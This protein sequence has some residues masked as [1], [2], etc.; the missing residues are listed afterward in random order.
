MRDHGA[1]SFALAAVLYRSQA[2]KRRVQTLIKAS[3][4]TYQVTR[5]A[6]HG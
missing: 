1:M 4:G 5:V 6:G 3:C 2:N